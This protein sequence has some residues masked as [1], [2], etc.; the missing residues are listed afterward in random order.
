MALKDLVSDLSNF[1]G[2]SQYDD[3]E[4]QIKKGVDF[5]DNETAGATGFTPKTN[6]ET[7]YNK[8]ISNVKENNVLPNQYTNSPTV[9]A[10]NA[11]VRLNDKTRSAYGTF[12]EYSEAGNPGLSNPSHV[13]SA[14]NIL[15]VRIQPQFLSDFM[16]TPLANYNSKLSPPDDITQTFSLEP[17][18]QSLPD[19]TQWGSFTTPWS[20]DFP[21]F[22]SSFM[23]TPLIGY[24]S[25]Y[26]SETTTETFTVP[27]EAWRISADSPVNDTYQPNFSPITLKSQ[28]NDSD[29]IKDLFEFSGKTFK[30]VPNGLNIYM[31]F[32]TADFRTVAN[33]GP[34]EGNNTHPIILRK[35]GSN[36]NNILNERGIVSEGGMIEGML[37][38]VGLLTRTNV[39]LEDK[40]RI[41]NFLESPKGIRFLGKQLA[42]QALN[43]TLESKIYN[44]LSA[45]GIAG[46]S[47]LLQGDI[48]GL[49]RAA[50]SFLFPTHVERHLGG[51]RYENVLKDTTNNEGRLYFQSKAF[52]LI[53][54]PEPPSSRINTGIGLL[55]SAANNAVDRAV[56]DAFFGVEAASISVPF[57]LS[58]PNKYGFLISSA[59]KSVVDGR[60]SFV[61]G[62]D[63][64]VK[65]VIKA[66]DSGGTFDPE[67]NVRR[68][69][70]GTG[71]NIRYHTSTY[72]EL[73]RE[74]SYETE[75]KM[76]RGQSGTDVRGGDKRD[77]ADIN[78]DV[79]NPGLSDENFTL[80][81][82][83]DSLPGFVKQLRSNNSIKSDAVDRVNIIPYGSDSEGNI[84]N[85]HKLTKDFIKFRFFDVVNRKFIIFRAILEGITDTITPEYGEERYIG[86]PDKLFTYQGVDRSLSFTFSIYPK[87]KQELP[88]LMEKLN[89]LIGLCYPSFTAGDR[90]VTPFIDLTLGDMFVSTP[91][92]LSSL[93]VTVE[94]QSTW[95]IS[96]G[97]QFPHFIKAACEFRHIG[98]HVPVSTGKHYDLPFGLN[99][100]K[101][102]QVDRFTND[103]VFAFNQ[104]PSREEPFRTEVFGP[105]GQPNE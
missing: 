74:N 104:Y 84:P 98:K 33:K 81:A 49:L 34:F 32:G 86:R 40:A 20:M 39:A 38:T 36:W 67:A 70:N 71:D 58:N 55:D 77:E 16:E 56:G 21:Q 57:S 2:Q 83:R 100:E 97:L 8:F 28:Y 47:D 3:L 12:G 54:F 24:T 15:G 46:A 26:S 93:T 48:S 101:Q 75:L 103:K 79:G 50:G 90:M 66:L 63:L 17:K 65:D 11:G 73:L 7:K 35:P 60:P 1:K 89:Y 13:L 82:T 87:T 4:N 45:V 14:D 88:V 23:T 68:R 94:E 105:L 96:D 25:Q 64:A 52:S 102:K 72:S 59:P 18:F 80:G 51:L 69:D 85:E 95:E 22:Q 30:N 41:Y 29:K 62:P 61:G 92:I 53:D 27:K 42:F 9:S 44:P 37:G 91:G 31:Q 19:F 5:F 6:L 10:P 78:K 43:P 99:D 76:P